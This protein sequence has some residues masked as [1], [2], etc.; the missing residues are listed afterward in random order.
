LRGSVLVKHAREVKQALDLLK[1]SKDFLILE[2]KNGFNSQRWMDDPSNYADVK[3]I[4][5]TT[6]LEFNELVE[7]QFIMELNMDLKRLEHKT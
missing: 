1:K 2:V 3:V 6:S 7:F 5:C 4:L